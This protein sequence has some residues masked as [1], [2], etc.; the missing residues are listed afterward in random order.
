MRSRAYIQA[1]LWSVLPSHLQISKNP[2]FSLKSNSVKS[3]T[4][5]PFDLR[6]EKYLENALRLQ[7]VWAVAML[8]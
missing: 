4:A 3:A 2:L 7:R 6:R 5:A 1:Q 8:V